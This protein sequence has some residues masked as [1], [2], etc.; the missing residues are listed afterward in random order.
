MSN[1]AIIQARV[2]STRLPGKVLK[3]ICGKTV[4]RH[5]VDRVNKSSMVD[6]VFVATTHKI[7][8]LSLIKECV[9]AGYNIFCG[10][11][12]DVL[13]RY[14]QL[15]K[16]EK[17]DTIIRITSDC[18]VIDPAIIDLVVSEHL[19]NHADYTCNTMITPFPDGQD[20]EVFSFDALEEAW[21][22]ATLH[23]DREHVTPYIKFNKGNFKLHFIESTEELASLRLT[24]DEESDLQLLELLFASLYKS[25]PYFSLDDIV[26]FI[27][28]N[29]ELKKINSALVREAGYHK[30]LRQ[31]ELDHD[32]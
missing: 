31:D 4:I 18:P 9:D 13:D 15:A 1:L 2:G 32:V 25:N 12:H 16:L 27:Y 6:K 23:S 19:N 14:Y 28:R 22:N 30:S 24:L 8:D 21:N 3:K 29:P 17:P 5:V 7:E 10:S 20:V 26:D 11:E